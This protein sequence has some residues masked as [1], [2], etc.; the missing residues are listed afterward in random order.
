MKVWRDVYDEVSRQWRKEWVDVTGGAAKAIALID[1]RIAELEAEDKRTAEQR[2]SDEKAQE[3][4]RKVAAEESQRQ[5]TASLLKYSGV[6]DRYHVASLKGWETQ[7]E[8]Q[9]AMKP[10]LCKWAFELDGRESSSAVWFGPAGTGKTYL[11]CGMLL[12]RYAR[13]L[14]GLYITAKG[15]TDR[16]K[17]SY[18]D[19]SKDSS[20]DILERY[21]STPILVL[22]EVGRQFETKSEDLYLFE[23]V[24]ERYNQ[25]RPTLFLSNLTNEEFR[26]FVGNAIMDRLREGGGKFLPFNWAS[27]RV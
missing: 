24:N 15:Y 23:L 25:Q 20:T 14:D 26:D 13:G 5:Y 22:D 2:L 27:R 9:A 7:D 1:Q 8:K 16:I 4:T 11:A 21:G 17:N 19:D 12:D 10:K 18:R 6:P 3:A